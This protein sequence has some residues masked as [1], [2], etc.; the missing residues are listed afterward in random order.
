MKLLVTKRD[1]TAA[2]PDCSAAGGIEHRAV[3]TPLALAICIAALTA[4]V[5][6]WSSGSAWWVLTQVLFLPVFVLP[7]IGRCR[8]CGAGLQMGFRGRWVKP[9]DLL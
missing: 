8:N 9:K 7:S 1:E 5:W 3:A 6:T 2:C 4:G